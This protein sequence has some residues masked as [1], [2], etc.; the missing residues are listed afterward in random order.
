M[1]TT[2]RS[3]DALKHRILAELERRGWTRAR[4]AE[5]VGV[6]KAA[7]SKW[8]EHDPG[9]PQYRRPNLASCYQMADIFG[10]APETVLTMAGRM[11]DRHQPGTLTPLQ[12][13]CKSMIDLIPDDVLAVVHPQLKVLTN[14]T[15]DDLWMQVD[16]QRA[17]RRARHPR[18]TKAT[19]ATDIRP[20][21][22]TIDPMVRSMPDE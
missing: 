3:S 16:I 5:A 4:F 1:A 14:R 12:A 11:P 21:H 9:D 7:V 10:E 6:E 15:L 19:A 17:A 2:D 13:S 22:Q 18:P 20:A 8:L